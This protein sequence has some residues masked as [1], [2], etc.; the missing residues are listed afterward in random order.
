[1]QTNTKHKV[2]MFMFLL[3]VFGVLFIIL[4]RTPP[5]ESL[6]E[7]EGDGDSGS[8]PGDKEDGRGESVIGWGSVTPVL[9][10]GGIAA[11]FAILVLT[12]SNGR[13]S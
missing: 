9:T 11:A 5:D 12:P 3:V 10:Y 4:R 13:Q 6:Y 8:S 2:L 1:M 7:D